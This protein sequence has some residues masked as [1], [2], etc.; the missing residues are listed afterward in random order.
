MNSSAVK[1]VI[2]SVLSTAVDKLVYYFLFTP[3]GTLKAQY[4]AR[5][6]SSLLNFNLNR[7]F[8][9]K[10]KGSYWKAMLKYYCVCI[11][12]VLIES[13]LLKSVLDKLN[14]TEPILATCLNFA[15]QLIIFCISYFIQKK[16][17]FKKEVDLEDGTEEELIGK[18]ENNA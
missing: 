10:S 13:F 11:P 1:Y 4:I 6:V 7:F 12:Q 8:A 3:L 14:V 16:W 9:F 15:V 5:A 18:N 17:V 2:S